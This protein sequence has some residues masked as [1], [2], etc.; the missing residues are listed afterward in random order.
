MK[1]NLLLFLLAASVIM[2]ASSCRKFVVTSGTPLSGTWYLESVSRYDGYRWQTISTGYESGT[3]Y[4]K[5]NG[6]ISYHDALGDL[7][8]SWNLYPVTSAY[9]DGYGHYTEGY[10]QVLAL[11]LYEAG[12]QHPAADWL[13]EDCDF[14]GGNSFA[15]AYTSGGFTYE[16]HF[17]RE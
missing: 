12:N 10:H 6:N 11:S 13:F 5:S 17:V 1:R 9:Y 3:F 4:F 2:L 16:F 7:Y 8:G 15:A 14:N